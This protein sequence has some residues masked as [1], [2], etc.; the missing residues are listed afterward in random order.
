ML[1]EYVLSIDVDDVVEDRLRFASCSPTAT[2]ERQ[3]LLTYRRQC[4]VPQTPT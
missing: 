2:V 3:M 4:Q 1:G